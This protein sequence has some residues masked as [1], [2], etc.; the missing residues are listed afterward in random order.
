MFHKNSS[1]KKL[2]HKVFEA[3]ILKATLISKKLI[4]MKLNGIF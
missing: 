2:F 3:E 1:K 4:I